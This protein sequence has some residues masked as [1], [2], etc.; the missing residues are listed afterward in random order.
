MPC[1]LPRDRRPREVQMVRSLR[2]ALRA[3]LVVSLALAAPAGATYVTFETGQVRPPALSPDGS[4]LFPINTP[5]DPLEIFT[6]D[7]TRNPTPTAS[8]PVRP[9]PCAGAPRDNG[10]GWGVKP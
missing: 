4:H 3:L 2:L 10:G 6:A 8:V 7:G 9:Q 5:H 1:Y